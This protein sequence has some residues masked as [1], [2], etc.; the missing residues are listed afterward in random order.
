M[1]VIVSAMMVVVMGMAVAAKLVMI[2]RTGTEL[3]LTQ[4]QIRLWARSEIALI[5]FGPNYRIYLSSLD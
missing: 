5:G 2:I 4:L 1:M 3:G